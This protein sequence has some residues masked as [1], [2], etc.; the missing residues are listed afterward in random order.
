MPNQDVPIES[1]AERAKRRWNNHA[2][3]K[4]F[5]ESLRRKASEKITLETKKEPS[6]GELI[7][8][9]KPSISNVTRHERRFVKEIREMLEG[10]AQRNV[11]LY[12]I[13]RQNLRRRLLIEKLRR[14]EA[15]AAS[16]EA[17]S[18]SQEIVK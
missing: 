13:S 16:R 1:A 5:K 15:R 2:V 3:E 10:K 12:K 18:E 14:L 8:T 7:T 6:I 11:E 9:I 4:A 17:Q